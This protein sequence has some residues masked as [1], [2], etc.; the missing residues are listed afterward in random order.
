MAAFATSPSPGAG[1]APL[2][3]LPDLP[4]TGG[5][6][7]QSSGGNDIMAALLSGIGPVKSQVD[8]ITAACKSIVQSGVIPGA[9][10]ICGQIVA[11]ATSLLPMAAQASVTSPT[12]QG[13]LQLPPSPA[14]PQPIQGGM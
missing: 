4:N 10:Q 3:P 2:P 1:A 12:G 6:S 5:G 11:L 13:G 14:G 8:Q 9:E 7:P